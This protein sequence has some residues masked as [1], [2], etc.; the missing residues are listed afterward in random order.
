[1]LPL[2]FTKTVTV[3]ADIIYYIVTGYFDFINF[4]KNYL[5]AVNTVICL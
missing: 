1:V 2:D 4:I 3:Y 5:I